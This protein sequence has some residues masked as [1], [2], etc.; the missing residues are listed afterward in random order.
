[1]PYIVKIKG[2]RGRLH[3][4]VV[5]PFETIL[6]ALRRRTNGTFKVNVDEE[7][8]SLTVYGGEKELRNIDS[9]RKFREDL[10]AA[11]DRA[12]I[13]YKLDYRAQKSKET[14]REDRI[15][16]RSNKKLEVMI[17]GLRRKIRETE[18][19]RDK[20]Q[21][22]TSSLQRTIAQLKREIRDIKIKSDNIRDVRD[23]LTTVMTR[24]SQLWE[25]FSESYKGLLELATEDVDMTPS[26]LERV[27]IDYIPLEENPN[28]IS[29]RKEYSQAQEAR[30]AVVKN[31]FLKLDK[32]A[33]E[34]LEIGDSLKEQDQRTR[35]TRE[36]LSDEVEKIILR[37]AVTTEGDDLYI[38]LPFR[39]NREY[40]G[41][42]QSIIKE[43]ENH[44]KE[45]GCDYTK[46][47]FNGLVR[48]K[49]NEMGLRKKRG[50]I[51]R[52]ASN[53]NNAFSKLKGQREIVQ[54]QIYKR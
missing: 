53:S 23:L 43:I 13:P 30:K 19:E 5:T 45:T 41:L 44:L 50:L 35:E 16:K 22:Q 28:F 36:V 24:E 21:Q 54:L 51:K 14:Q 40:T 18:E 47:D 2:H 6:K 8:R 15:Q 34:I 7:N 33:Q 37:I 52:L 4:N 32:K 20:Y 11:L 42:E 25:S 9:K 31:P 3:A 10:K 38:I 1:M 49:V 39:A 46:Q 48:Y 26:E 17:T 12:N 29:I 27:C